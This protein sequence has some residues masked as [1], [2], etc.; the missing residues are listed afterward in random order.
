MTLQACRVLATGTTVRTD[1]LEEIQRCMQLRTRRTVESK[2]ALIKLDGKRYQAS[3]NLGG[4]R[5]QVR[6]PFDDDSAV[7]IWKAGAFLERAERFVPA[8]DIDYSKRPQRTAKEEGPKVLDCSKRL[9]L[10]LVS[11]YR[12]QKAPEDTSR[13]GVLTEREFTYV[14]E[15]C[16]Q[17]ALTE[18]DAGLLSQCYKRLSPFD[19]EFAQR[20]LTK[21]IAAKGTRKHLS[22]YLGR[23]EEMKKYKR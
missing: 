7:N 20:C 17:R 8:A 14:V 21:A 2:T 22:F 16:L 6:W 23:L 9:R 4:K 18:A 1:T 5:V 19:A 15:Q 13:Y 10:S 11:R 3:Q 12:G